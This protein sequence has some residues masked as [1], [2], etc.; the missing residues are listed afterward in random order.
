MT[1]THLLALSLGVTMIGTGVSAPAWSATPKAAP[2][3]AS[4]PQPNI[5]RLWTAEFMG[6]GGGGHSDAELTAMAKRFDVIAAMPKRFSPAQIRLMKAANPK[7]ELAVYR[8]ATF[9]PGNLT[10]DMYAHDANGERIHAIRWPTTYL[11]ELGSAGW[12]RKVASS[13]VDQVRAS[14]YDYCYLDVLGNAPIISEGYINAWPVHPD[15]TRWTPQEWITWT[16]QISQGVTNAMGRQQY[17]NGYGAG[18]RYFHPK[19]A[20][21]PLYAPNKQVAAE[22]FV[23]SGRDPV[24]SWYSETDWKADVDMLV[25]TEKAGRGMMTITKIWTDT[26]TPEATKDRIHEYALATFLLG[27]GGK[28][29]FNFLREESPDAPLMEHPYNKINP[30]TP[31]NSYRKVGGVYRR[32]FSRALVL[33]NPTTTA[34]TVTLTRSYTTMNGQ[35][36]RGSVRMAPHTAR[37]LRF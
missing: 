23:R 12:Q 27:T 35:T 29:R 3:S 22:G 15:G 7:L 30:G 14:G 34:R 25:D 33:V 20:S 9:G 31:V 10:E 1:K 36:V 26:P 18:W 5:L 28:S 21:K 16:A 24:T 11:M 4:A 2:A 19:F 8:N 37:I 13:C 32:D 17:G 6:R